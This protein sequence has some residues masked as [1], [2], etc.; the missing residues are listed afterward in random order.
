MFIAEKLRQENIAEYLLYMW[1]V[2]DTIRAYGCDA[3]RI[4]REYV[5]QFRLDAEKAAKLS[6]WYANLCAMMRSEGVREKGHLQINR[7]VTAELA[8][9]SQQLLESH[10]FPRYRSAYFR[11]LPDIMELR[12]KGNAS[13]LSDI[14]VCFNALYGV[15]LL[16][17]GKKP[18]SEG[19]EAAAKEIS[20]V[21][22]LLAAYYR[23]NRKKPLDFDGTNG[24]S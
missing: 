8:E 6:Q 20:G 15:M 21:I 5:P 19:T 24:I 14:E 12:K 9:L 23:E 10:N 4:A 2:E 18:V 7:N 17:L 16:R 22:A 3:E 11:A 13:T 1:Q